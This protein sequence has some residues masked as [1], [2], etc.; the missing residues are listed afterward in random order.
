MHLKI[1]NNILSKPHD[2]QSIPS[3]LILDE[4]NKGCPLISSC[5][6]WQ[7]CVLPPALMKK[8]M[9]TEDI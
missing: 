2:L 9:I 7:V 3:T 4:V 6:L 5:A 8:W 1:V